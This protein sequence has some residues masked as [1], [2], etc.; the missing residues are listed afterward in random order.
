MA[1]KRENR[2]V[3]MHLGNKKEEYEKIIANK[4]LFLE[5][6]EYADSIDWG[7]F[8]DKQKRTP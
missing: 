2:T 3:I 1:K 7:C 4:D 5:R 6:V 8:E